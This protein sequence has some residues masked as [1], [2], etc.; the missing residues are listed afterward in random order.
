M[1]FSLIFPLVLLV[2]TEK[3]I[4][5]RVIDFRK[6]VREGDFRVEESHDS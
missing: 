6:Y 5:D 4:K 1:L 3:V 2:I